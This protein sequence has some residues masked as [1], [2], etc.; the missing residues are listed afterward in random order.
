LAKEN[1]KKDRQLLNL[2]FSETDIN[3]FGRE[4]ESIGE[5]G[6]DQSPH[7]K[8]HSGPIP[9]LGPMLKKAPEGHLTSTKRLNKTERGPVTKWAGYDWGVTRT[10]KGPT[11]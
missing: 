8:T 3:T 10:P 4:K 5:R 6:G 9:L 1:L 11:P 7:L 2:D